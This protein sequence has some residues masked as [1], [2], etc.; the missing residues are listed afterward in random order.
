MDRPTYE[1]PYQHGHDDETDEER[2]ER[3]RR[4][5]EAAGYDPDN[6]D[7]MDGMD[8]TASA[9]DGNHV[10]P[11]E[12]EGVRDADY[13]TGES[14]DESGVRD[15]DVLDDG[16]ARDS[17]VPDSD[18]REG[19]GVLRDDDDLRAADVRDEARDS[20]VFGSDV[21]D[22][23][24]R[25]GNFRDDVVDE[26]GLPDSRSDSGLRDSDVLVGSAS[27]YAP[28]GFPEGSAAPSEGPPDGIATGTASDAEIAETF[29]VAEAPTAASGPTDYSFTSRVLPETPDFVQ[30]WHEIKASF[31]DD[32]RK[33]VEMADALVEEAVNALT[34][35]REALS[36]RWRNAE[37]DD[38]EQLRLTLRE[39]HALFDQL[40]T[41]K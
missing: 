36:D 31:V 40:N 23:G 33:S 38:T 9:A 2:L 30:R 4:E 27:G 16:D 35:I 6:P 25:D 17:D 3:E 18:V 26:D 19:D 41:G 15:S 10:A 5:R 11:V 29:A 39:Y 14:A 7:G 22:E 12:G 20:E 34:A 32:P 8:A 13:R 28:G 1:M 24:V 37:A 21:E